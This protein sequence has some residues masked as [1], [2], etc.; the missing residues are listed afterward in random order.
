M[1][2]AALQRLIPAAQRSCLWGSTGR[3]T[4]ATQVRP[5][6]PSDTQGGPALRRA[7]LVRTSNGHSGVVRLYQAG[8]QLGSE[9][10]SAHEGE[11]WI[12]IRGMRF[13]GRHGVLPEVS[14]R[15]V[16]Q[17]YASACAPVLQASPMRVG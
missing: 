15:A 5:W 2:L 13:H 8:G 7:S 3:A 11:D 14:P 1:H 9:Q 16:R 6:G 17:A 10:R 4:V 12:H